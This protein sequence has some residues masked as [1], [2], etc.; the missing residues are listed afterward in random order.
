MY[1]GVLFRS[2]TEARWAALFEAIGWAWSYEPYD[3]EG[4]IPDFLIRL[5]KMDLLVEVK[6]TDE[7][8]AE[9]KRKV[10]QTSYDGIAL[11]VGQDVEGNVLGE[12]REH[13]GPGYVWSEADVFYCL[14]CGKISV[15]PIEMSWHCRQCGMGHGNA[16]IGDYDLQ[17]TFRSASNRV[18]WRPE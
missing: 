7:D 18:Q 14:S 13:D 10:D 5:P 2:R 1:E 3:L 15:R 4:W 9:A 6:S 8:F 17:A 16:H 11:V 12:I